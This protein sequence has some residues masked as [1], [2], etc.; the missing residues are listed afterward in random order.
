D[1]Q[2]RA[3]IRDDYPP[4]DPW[5]AVGDATVWEG[6]AK[7]TKATFALTLSAPRPT[8]TTV[9]F[10]TA[11]GSAVAPG[12]YTSAS[13]SV[14]IPTGRTSASVTVV[15]KGDVLVEP[16]GMFTLTLT[17]VPPGIT[18]ADGVGLG[19]IRNDD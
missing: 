9:F 12:D 8:D 4:T 19:T 5:L 14:T 1:P 2:G 7:T 11:D 6:D 13:G 18:V 16:D 3:V 17:S 15:V 10:A